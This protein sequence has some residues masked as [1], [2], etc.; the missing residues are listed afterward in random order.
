MHS[1][2]ASGPFT[3]ISSALDLSEA[4]YEYKFEGDWNEMNEGKHYFA[5]NVYDDHGNYS[6]SFTVLANVPDFTNPQTP[7]NF[8]GYIDSM[9]IVRLKWNRS[10]SMDANGYW[11]Y[12]SHTQDGE[13][14]LVKQEM[15]S[16]TNYI[17]YIPE[18]SLNKYIYY[19]LRAEDFAYNRSASTDILK[20]K[21]LDK[22]APIPPSILKVYNDSL[23][24][25]LDIKHSPS[26]DCIKYYIYRRQANSSDTS[27]QLLDS[28]KTE[29]LYKDR[30]TE[31]GKTYYYKVLGVDDSGNK[32]EL[33]PLKQATLLLPKEELVVKNL[34]I[35]QNNKSGIELTWDFELPKKLKDEK[36]TYEIFKSSGSES[37]HFYKTLTKD[38]LLFIDENLKPQ[39]LYNYAV[40]IHFEDGTSG[41][42]SK[43]KSILIK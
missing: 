34:K 15:I 29:T 5:M 41:A 3:P 32:S 18:K 2:S 24:L 19:A 17:Y 20:V 38:E 12:W 39:S 11:L 7:E 33:S 16:D 36:Y 9:G 40:R 23:N 22:I 35:K 10:R 28:I 43:T 13:F 1:R 8:S 21:R 14:S 31:V 4:G 30:V 25:V 37:V 6:T 27:W 42:L 26:E